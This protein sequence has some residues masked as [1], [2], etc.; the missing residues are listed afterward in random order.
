LVVAVAA[1][2]A[3]RWSPRGGRHATMTEESRR[4]R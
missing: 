2:V 1:V 3:M 4:Q